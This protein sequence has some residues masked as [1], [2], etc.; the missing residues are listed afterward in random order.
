MTWSKHIASAV[1]EMYDMLS[2]PVKCSTSFKISM[3]LAK[4]YLIPVLLYG[5][6]IDA[7]FDANDFRKL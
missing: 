5:C 2:N 3:L 6:E 4:I 7:Y 1:G